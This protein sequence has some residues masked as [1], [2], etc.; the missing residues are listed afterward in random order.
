MN[1]LEQCVRANVFNIELAGRI[2]S[3]CR[4]VT[5]LAVKG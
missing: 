2:L 4:E 5:D 3:E 1:V